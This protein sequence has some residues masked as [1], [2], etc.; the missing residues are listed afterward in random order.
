M[1]AKAGMKKTWAQIR[2][3]RKREWKQKQKATPAGGGSKYATK[4]K[5]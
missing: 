4:R 2:A 5:R 3:Q 1:S